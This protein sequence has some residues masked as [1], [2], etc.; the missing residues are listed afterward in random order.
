M[1]ISLE[2]SDELDHIGI[3]TLLQN[4]DLRIGEFLYLG[5]GLEDLLRDD[6]DGKLL[7]PLQIHS[8]IDDAP[9]AMADHLV[10]GDVMLMKGLAGKVDLFFLHNKYNISITYQYIGVNSINNRT[11]L[12]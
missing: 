4:I 8:I 2:T 11:D 12:S 1:T 7:S 9:V 6:L 3:I 10:D 5:S